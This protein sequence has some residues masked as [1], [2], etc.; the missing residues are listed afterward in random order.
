MTSGARRHAAFEHALVRKVAGEGAAPSFA[1]VDFKASTMAM[2][3]VFD[4][5]E[6]ETR[7]PGV[8]GTPRIDAVE[9]LGEPRNVFG[10]DAGPRVAHGEMTPVRVGPPADLHAAFGRRV[11]GRVV[12]E[13]R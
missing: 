12:D 8:A 11:L 3:R 13:I 6:P 2:Q 5:G 10:G 7:A 4:D 1:A 9:A